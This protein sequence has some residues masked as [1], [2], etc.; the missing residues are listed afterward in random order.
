MEVAKQPTRESLLV[1]IT[2][3][4]FSQRLAKERPSPGLN[5]RAI[6]F[7]VGSSFR[8]DGS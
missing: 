3:A 8:K 7:A 2:L 5:L 1:S 4:P 6:C